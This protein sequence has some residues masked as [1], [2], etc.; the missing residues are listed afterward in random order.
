MFF[1]SLRAGGT[2]VN[3]TAA[4][5]V[6]LMDPWWN[7]AVEEQAIDRTHRIGQ[8]RPVTAYRLIAAGTVEEKIASLQERKRRLAEDIV[9]DEQTTIATLSPEELLDLFS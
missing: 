7:P 5:Y 8:T 3:L 9:P 2:G 1:I 6:V 4:D